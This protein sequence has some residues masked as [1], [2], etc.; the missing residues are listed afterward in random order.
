M[1]NTMSETKAT[2]IKV[3][4]K[5]GL[6]DDKG[7]AVCQVDGTILKSKDKL[8]GTVIADKYEIM[9]PLGKGGMSM[10][11]K[12]KH[13]MMD[14]VVAVK[15]LRPELCAI[16]QLVERFKNESRAISS[17]RHPGI[18]A[19]FDFGLMK[20]A[21]PFLVMDYLEGETLDKVL[22]E[23]EKI[24]LKEAVNLVASA[25]DA[26]NHSHTKGIIHRD[27]KPSNLLVRVETNGK[28][29]L[30]IFDFGIAKMLSQD[31]QTIHKLTSSGEIFGSPLYMSPEQ[32]EGAKIDARS[33]IYSMACVLHEMILGKPPF[34]GETP[35]ETIMMHMNEEAKPFTEFDP[36]HGIPAELEAAIHKALSKSAD[37]RFQS[38]SEFHDTIIDAATKVQAPEPEPSLTMSAELELPAPNDY[39]DN[40]ANTPIS[41]NDFSKSR[42]IARGGTSSG[43]S[44]AH[45]T[46]VA[47]ALVFVVL[48][49]GGIY[50]SLTHFANNS[51]FEYQTGETPKPVD[52]TTGG[53]K[54]KAPPVKVEEPAASGETEMTIEE[55]LKVL[56]VK[57]VNQHEQLRLLAAPKTLDWTIDL[58]DKVISKRPKPLKRESLDAPEPGVHQTAKY[59]I[60]VFE[61][62]PQ[63]VSSSMIAIG[64]YKK[65]FSKEALAWHEIS[66]NLSK[67]Y[68][69]LVIQEIQ[70]DKAAGTKENVKQ[71]MVYFREGKR[72]IA[73][74]FIPQRATYEEMLS[75]IDSYLPVLEGA[76]D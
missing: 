40:A 59:R 33:D 74:Q 73:V 6:E 51:S 11:Y 42:G 17:L 2:K 55:L 64:M 69:D 36:D 43:I 67:K 31:G 76:I 70:Y 50:V 4:P 28:K 57:K 60:L 49:T 15:L 45:T 58:S 20:N 68:K 48:C 37:E 39:G 72:L 65:F 1:A 29:T 18:V 7:N 63:D 61:V 46:K 3:C 8:I 35:V 27:I 30:T 44:L 71:F 22:K 34:R 32:S 56:D 66:V 12:A 25:C 75:V 38:I 13:K 26:L 14:R 62:A 54:T 9:S 5:C 16:P 47:A 23:Q 41:G 19:V 21:T 52:D 10:V 24:E 53:D